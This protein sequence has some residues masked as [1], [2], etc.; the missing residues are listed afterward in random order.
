MKNLFSLFLAL[1]C[2]NCMFAEEVLNTDFTQGKDDWV[3]NDVTLDGVTYVWQQN[4]SYGM[5]ASA[6]YQSANHVSE[7]SSDSST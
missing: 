3:I 2:V 1:L 7:S 4:S 6:F 5:K